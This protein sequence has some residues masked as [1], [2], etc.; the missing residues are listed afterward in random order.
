MGQVATSVVG[1]TTR[2]LAQ[3]LVRQNSRSDGV[4]GAPTHAAHGTGSTRQGR[5]GGTGHHGA[6]YSC[7][8]A[9]RTTSLGRRLRDARFEARYESPGEWMVRAAIRERPWLRGARPFVPTRRTGDPGIMPLMH[10][11]RQ[12][13]P[14]S[15]SSHGVRCAHRAAP[16]WS[17]PRGRRRTHDSTYGGSTHRHHHPGGPGWSRRHPH[18]DRRHRAVRPRGRRVRWPRR[19]PGDRLPGGGR[20]VPRVLRRCAAAEAVG[21]APR[22]GRRRRRASSWAPSS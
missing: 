22:R 18:G 3:P 6:W 21:L 5:G 16:T 14:L 4:V 2:K 1:S 13:G 8:S 19:A 15:G 12:M 10:H 20:A 7:A 9:R 17:R 11:I